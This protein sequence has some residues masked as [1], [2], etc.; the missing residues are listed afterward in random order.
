MDL[1][2]S[3]EDCTSTRVVG[4]EAVG[5]EEDCTSE[6]PASSVGDEGMFIGGR[7]TSEIVL[8]YVK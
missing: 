1:R 8:R 6:D 7:A 3:G 2:G 5:A 4:T